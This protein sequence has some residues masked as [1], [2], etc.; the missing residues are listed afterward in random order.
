MHVTASLIVFL[1]EVLKLYKE[2][3]IRYRLTPEN[4]IMQIL[5]AYPMAKHSGEKIHFRST[6]CILIL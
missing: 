5:F 3:L 6:D 1:T 4:L 2:L